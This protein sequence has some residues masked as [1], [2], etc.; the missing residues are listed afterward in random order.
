MT[1]SSFEMESMIRGYHIYKDIWMAVDGEV[2]QSR[3]E[4]SNGLDPFAVAVV[5]DSTVVGHLPRRI[6]AVCSLFLRRHGTIACRVNGSRRYSRDLSQGGLEVPCILIFSGEVLLIKKVKGLIDDVIKED[7]SNG[8]S[9][10]LPLKTPLMGSW[11]DNFVQV[12]H[13]RGNHWITVSPLRCKDGEINV[14][15]LYIQALILAL[16]VG[17][18]QTKGGILLTLIAEL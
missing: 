1:S 14:T 8:V 6:S 16:N 4:T 12:Y 10:P 5:K 15:T 13:C 18:D 17:K 3:R 7:K 9:P 11:T 2:L